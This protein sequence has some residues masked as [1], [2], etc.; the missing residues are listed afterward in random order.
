MRKLLLLSIAVAGLAVGGHSARAANCALT[1]ISLTIGTTVYNPTS[2]ASNVLTPPQNPTNDTA[3][4]NLGLGTNFSW[5]AKD[6]GTFAV[7]DGIKYTVSNTAGT[8]GTWTVTWTDTNGPTPL[9]FPV[10]EDMDVGFDGGA[11]GDAYEFTN[12]I[13]PASPNS[14]TGSFN[15]TFLNNGGQHPAISGLNIAVGNDQDCTPALCPGVTTFSTAP[16][17]ASLALL[18]VGLFGLGLV[19]RR[20]H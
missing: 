7:L 15:I 11:N 20:R 17:P 8:S 16:E 1:D 14:G 9:N 3:N 19:A 13:L 10:I 6:D 4:M 5:V 2:C 12:L 18:G